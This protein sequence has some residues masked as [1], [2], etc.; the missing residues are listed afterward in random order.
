MDS[1]KYLLKEELIEDVICMNCSLTRFLEKL[2]DHHLVHK[3]ND[4]LS[5]CLKEQISLVK[6]LIEKNKRMLIDSEDLEQTIVELKRKQIIKM[7]EFEK[8]LAEPFVKKKG[9]VRSH[10]VI[11]SF[12][13][14]GEKK[15]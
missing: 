1:L 10:N 12:P 15:N 6:N 2:G 11:I 7:P 8:S 9:V 13:V 14:N 3:S 5:G 4:A